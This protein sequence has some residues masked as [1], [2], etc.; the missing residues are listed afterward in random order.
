MS[1]DAKS[2][3][4]LSEILEQNHTIAVVGIK[5]REGED[6]YRIPKYMQE[7]GYTIVPVNPKLERV[8]GEKAYA[9]LREL[10][11]DVHVDVVNLFRA[12]D[13]VPDHVEEILSMKPLPRVVWLQLGIHD[14]PSAAR[15]RAEGITV[16]QDRCIKV[17]HAR[18]LGADTP[19]ASSPAG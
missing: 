12:T 14:G 8:L 3:S 2:D 10:D 5:D 16:I 13:N 6:A 15:M 17:D 19:P 4:Q 7:H 1:N 18:L 9:S 11:D